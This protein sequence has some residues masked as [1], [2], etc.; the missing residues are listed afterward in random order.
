MNSRP[1]DLTTLSDGQHRKTTVEEGT[2]LYPRLYRYL[3]RLP[4]R[5]QLL[6]TEVESRLA[7]A[8]VFRM[9]DMFRMT[10]RARWSVTTRREALIG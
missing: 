8:I 7:I 1:S 9:L 10:A 4:T 6:S 5:P 3:K 2:N